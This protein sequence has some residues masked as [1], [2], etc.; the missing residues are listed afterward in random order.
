MDRAKGLYP[1]RVGSLLGEV[2]IFPVIDPSE[3]AACDC[4]QDNCYVRGPHARRPFSGAVGWQGD[5]SCLAEGNLAV[6][7]ALRRLASATTTHIIEVMHHSRY[8]CG[9]RFQFLRAR[10]GDGTD[11]L[12]YLR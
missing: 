1:M 8:L 5:T 11:E 3:P 6:Q 9:L 12:H 4:G 7:L 2:H 10:V